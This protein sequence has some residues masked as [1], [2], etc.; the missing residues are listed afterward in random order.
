MQISVL[1]IEDNPLTSQDLS[2]I[3]TENGFA[4]LGVCY[5][6]EDALTKV[7]NLNPDVLLV[8]IQLK[9]EMTGID[10]VQSFDNAPSF[11]M[12]LGLYLGVSA[13]MG[14]LTV[15]HHA[16]TV[17]GPKYTASFEELSR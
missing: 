13:V 3:L 4:V 2:E 10:L 12:K 8:D 15:R 14:Y 16:K 1:I 5:S 6:G 17:L 11:M 9:G 7:E